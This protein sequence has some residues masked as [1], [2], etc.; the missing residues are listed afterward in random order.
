MRSCCV[1]HNTQL[2]C[3]DQ[4]APPPSM[5]LLQIT[6][7]S[8]LALFTSFL[9]QCCGLCAFVG[10]NLPQAC[11]V[12]V[13]LQ[14]CH[15]CCCRNARGMHCSLIR[16]L[17]VTFRFDK[18]ACSLTH[19]HCILP[20]STHLTTTSSE[21]A[22]HCTSQAHHLLTVDLSH[23]SHPYAQTH[24]CPAAYAHAIHPAE[25]NVSQCSIHPHLQQLLLLP[26]A[27]TLLLQQPRLR[28]RHLQTVSL[29]TFSPPVPLPR[30]ARLFYELRQLTAGGQ[31]P[32]LVYVSEQVCAAGHG[33]RQNPNPGCGYPQ[34]PFYRT[35]NRPTH[36][37]PE[38]VF[39]CIMCVH[40]LAC[41][42][43]GCHV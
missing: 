30:H 8:L 13:T 42:V 2:P 12:K 10:P 36:Q 39:L 35:L 24:L 31:Q 43:P 22:V 38:H 32:Q 33:N 20:A 15:T 37:P 34:P 29:H 21:R 40:L 18:L 1:G 3:A 17:L 6:C 9:L 5:R 4:T 25:S 28:L 14:Q 41:S 11:C 19:A 26:L 27:A 16:R 23:I 7:I